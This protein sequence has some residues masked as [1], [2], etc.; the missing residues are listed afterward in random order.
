MDYRFID[1]LWWIDGFTWIHNWYTGKK[2]YLTSMFTNQHGESAKQIRT[3]CS[4]WLRFRWVEMGQVT[5]SWT[6]FGTCIYQPFS[7]WWF[8]T[9][10]L[11]FRILGMS[12]SQL[13]FIFFRG[14]GQPPTSFGVNR[15]A[16]ILGGLT[17]LTH[18][19]IAAR[20]HGGW[21]QERQNNQFELGQAKWNC[22]ITCFLENAFLCFNGTHVTPAIFVWSTPNMTRSKIF[23]GPA[24][25]MYI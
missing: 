1:G 8:G 13:T 19:F 14:V 24:S 25:H 5:T 18:P 22:W 6:F 17:H 23:C 9:W 3:N 20:L 4:T 11:F 15:V 21:K 10:I 16:Y 2:G 12:S 7:S